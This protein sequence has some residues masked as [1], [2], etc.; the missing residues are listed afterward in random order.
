MKTKKMLVSLMLIF[1]MIVMTAAGCFT[2]ESAPKPAASYEDLLFDTSRV[3]MI[4]I[5]MSEEDRAESAERKKQLEGQLAA[6]SEEQMEEDKV[7]A[8]GIVI[9]DMG[10]LDD[11]KQQ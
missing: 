4:E 8:D 1:S 11:L 2:M 3:H 6:K 10:S 7:G 9:S 5:S